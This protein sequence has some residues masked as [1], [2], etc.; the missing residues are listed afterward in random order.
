MNLGARINSSSGDF[1][2]SVTPDGK[3]IFFSS[4]RS[5]TPEKYQGRS[6]RE[7]VELFSSPQNGYAALYWADASILEALRPDK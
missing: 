2:A 5:H 3:C 1:S 7:I 4:Y 6:Y